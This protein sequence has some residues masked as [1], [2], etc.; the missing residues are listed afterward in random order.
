MEF[1]VAC[2]AVR[3]VDRDGF[4]RPCFRIDN[5]NSNTIISGIPEVFGAAVFQSTTAVINIRIAAAVRKC[6]RLQTKNRR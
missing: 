2:V 5:G 4:Y 6:Y 1:Y 3:V